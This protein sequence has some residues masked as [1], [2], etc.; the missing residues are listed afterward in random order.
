MSSKDIAEKSAY[1]C[2]WENAIESGK[3]NRG[4]LQINFEFLMQSG[5]IK[6]GQKALELGCGSGNLA[7]LLYDEGISIIG[8]DI[9]QS[10]VDHARQQYPKIDF[11]V[12]SADALPYD[13][14]TFDL[15]MSFDVFEHLP[16]VDRHL[17]E[18][19]RV[20]KNNGYY[21]LQ[22]PNKFS[23]IIFETLKTRSLAWKKYH[24]S[25]HFFSQLKRRLKKNGFDPQ[26]IK[27]NTM[28]EFAAN[29]F[30]RVGLPGWLFK[31]IDFRYMPFRL[32]TNFYVI[33]KKI[34]DS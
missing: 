1:E 19:R 21:V 13:N 5:L 2:C 9:S 22:T 4:N 15:V 11:K 12:H 25:L 23:N 10:A 26:F 30:Q 34:N 33:A 16:D 7:S 24:P 27:M 18:V 28:N 20:L 31:W 3:I 17:S 29:K 6:S 8:S 14:Q 32:Q